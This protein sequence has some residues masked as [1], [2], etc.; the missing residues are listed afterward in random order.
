MKKLIL[1]SALVI[2]AGACGVPLDIYGPIPYDELQKESTAPVLVD[3][4]QIGIS[5][6]G[7][8]EEHVGEIGRPDK[9]SGERGGVTAIFTGTGDPVCII[10]DPEG[11]DQDLDPLDDGDVDMTGGRL[12]DYTGTPGVAFGDFKSLYI[13][14]LGV[15]HED[16]VNSCFTPYLDA[17]G[18]AGA[19]GGKGQ[20]EYCLFDTEAGVDYVAAAETF[21]VPKDDAN[22]VVSL[23]VVESEINGTTGDPECPGIDETTLLGDVSP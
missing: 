8:I 21:S 2:L 7:N 6:F 22:L 15:E 9:G 13:D 4:G 11:R 3:H 14:P 1:A 19:P 10:I 17:F 23:A 5:T 12:A 18:G 16:D 20:V